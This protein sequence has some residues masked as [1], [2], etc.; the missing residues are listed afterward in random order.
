M[1]SNSFRE[2]FRLKNS[3][4]AHVSVEHAVQPYR[5]V[6]VP[7]VTVGLGVE[8]P[9]RLCWSCLASSPKWSAFL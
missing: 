2:T 7:W 9:V 4:G 5:R 1:D 6:C 8:G 3:A